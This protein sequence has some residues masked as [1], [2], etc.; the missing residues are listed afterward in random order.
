M[1][2]EL[3]NRPNLAGIMREQALPSGVLDLIRIAAGCRETLQSAVKITGAGELEIKEASV[4]FL[5]QVLFTPT[6]SYYRVLGVQPDAPQAELREHMRWL[7]KWLHPDQSQSDWESTFAARVVAAWNVLKSKEQ[8][9]LYDRSL[10]LNRPES[11]LDTRRRRRPK[12]YRAPHRVPWVFHQ[13]GIAE[14]TRRNGR[15]TALVALALT[16]AAVVLYQVN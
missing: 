9:T 5:Q 6:A 15:W 8:R 2:V 3:A 11:R 14:S 12:V 4:L 1:A 10:D 16:I 7:M 13:S